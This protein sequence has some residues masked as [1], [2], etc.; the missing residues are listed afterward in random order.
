MA[1]AIREI[2]VEQGRD[3]RRAAL[4]AFG[5]AGP[6]FATLLARELGVAR[7]VV[8]RHAGNFSAWGLLGADVTRERAR[9]RI[10]R[11]SDE[12]LAQARALLDEL[13]AELGSADGAVREERLDMRYVGQE[14]T[15]TV[16]LPRGAEPEGLRS[17]FARDY[18]RT[19]G[20]TMEEEVEI[21]SV[22]ATLR[23]P[24][25]RRAREQVLAGSRDG[26]GARSGEAWSFSRGEPLDFAIVERAT[27]A[28]GETV[29]GPAIV[30][31]P[32]ATTYV[33]ADF[34]ARVDT[35]GSLFLRKE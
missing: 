31:E 3:P 35:S 29:P 30:L 8:P 17:L 19:F 34:T 13:S 28:A 21:V 18:D 20:H 6:L 24:L 14:H 25:P 9:T 22:R 5:G 15:L 23:T 27:L 10:L 1:D 16:T 26:T 11:L 33:D 2:T 7:V 4:V 32:T 12:G